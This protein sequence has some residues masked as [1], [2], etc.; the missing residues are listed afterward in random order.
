MKTLQRITLFSVITLLTACATHN[1]VASNKLIQ[2]RKYRSGFYYE[3]NNSIFKNNDNS[4]DVANSKDIPRQDSAKRVANIESIVDRNQIV[5]IEEPY[6]LEKIVEEQ[7]EQKSIANNEA[8]AYLGDAQQL[9]KRMNQ[10]LLI[11]PKH[12]VKKISVESS[13]NQKAMHQHSEFGVLG[14]LLLV[15][16]ALIIPPLA[17]VI[18]DGFSGRFWLTLLLWLIGIGLGWWLLGPTIGWICGLIAVIYALIVILGGN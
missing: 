8:D 11:K 6:E 10:K 18:Y 9:H 5:L 14:I 16:I 12:T 13:K 1:D 4:E 3:K 7:R 15:I 2:K 17:V